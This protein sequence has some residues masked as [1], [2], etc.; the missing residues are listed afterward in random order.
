MTMTIT[1][2]AAV[3]AMSVCLSSPAVA[4]EEISTAPVKVI[5][6]S[7]EFTLP[8]ELE[9]FGTQREV[10][11]R[12]DLARTGYSD[13]GQALQWLVPGLFIAPKNGPAD[14]VNASMQGSR[15]GDIL[16][17]VDGVRINNRLYANT[18]PLDSLTTEMVQRIEVL[19]GGQ[20]LFYGTQAVAGVVNVVLREPA[21]ETGGAFHAGAGSFQTREASGH[22][23]D[24][25]LGGELLLFAEN[26]QAE[27]FQPFPDEAYQDDARRA[28][29]GYNRTSIGGKYRLRPAA[30][31]SLT[32]LL[33]RNDARADY[34]RPYGN[35]KSFNDR[36]E[37]IVSLKWDHWLT[38]RSGYFV[39]AYYHDW[40]TDYTLLNM[41]TAG[42][43]TVANDE[44]RWGYEDYGVNLMGRHGFSDGSEIVAGL[45]HQR[46][47]GEDFVLRIDRKEETVTAAFVQ[48]RPVL[49]FDP[50][51]ALALGGRYNHAD[52]GGDG[53]V[54]NIT[55][56]RPLIAGMELSGELGTGFRLPSAYELFTSDP[57][58]PVGNEDLD[59]ERSL[60]GRLGL[61]GRMSGNLRWELHG[62]YREINDLIAVADDTFVN[63]DGTVYVRG[64]EAQ[65]RLGGDRGGQAAVSATVARAREGGSDE[66]VD[67]VPER[68]AKLRVGY[69]AADGRYSVDLN[70]LYA[71]ETYSTLAIGRERYGNYTVVDMSG[72]LRLGA[73]QAHELGLRIGN[74][75]DRDYATQLDDG[76][77]PAGA[78]YVYEN[79]GQPRNLQL[80]YRYHF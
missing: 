33:Q 73:D 15:S 76:E 20:G 36:D 17:L 41:D 10:I 30:G 75:L 6:G 77:T 80:D 39:K 47:W 2:A 45:E 7:L 58:H 78:D 50:Q 49:P 54:W 12:E 56:A 67:E 74:L 4:A 70:A 18:S 69:V 28:N 53:A 46:Y 65:L 25:V 9:A 59:A 44:D 51:T 68:H 14:Y 79:R 13:I 32:L 64:A 35:F 48:L 42:N 40:W 22:V 60:G 62:F 66:Q 37:H 55:A 61:T 52:F 63:T 27:G 11:T 23:T 57:D 3:A 72:R 24:G 31:Q 34:A 38:E 21:D 43:V 5:A 16:W 71:G 8:E 1:R 19:K 29:R 26:Q